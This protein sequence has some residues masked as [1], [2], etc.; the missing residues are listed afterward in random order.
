MTLN[1]V[2]IIIIILIVVVVAVAVVINVKKTLNE[3]LS[4]VEIKIPGIEIP[5]PQVTVKVQRECDSDEFQVHVDKKSDPTSKQ[6]VGLSPID[7]KEP[8]EQ[9]KRED[10]NEQHVCI[11]RKEYEKLKQ[12]NDV[13]TA[14]AGNVENYQNYGTLDD[15]GKIKLGKENRFA[16]PKNYL[17]GLT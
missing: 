5:Q 14:E 8:F 3:K 17:F 1:K 4:N 13:F 12:G 2:D 16:K 9:I 10:H 7:T 15:I 6:V 11:S